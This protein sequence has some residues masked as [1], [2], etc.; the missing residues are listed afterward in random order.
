MTMPFRLASFSLV[1]AAAL[2]AAPANADI[3]LSELVVELQPGKAVREDVEVW[4]NGKERTYVAVEPAEVLNPGTPLE[5]RQQE[6]DPEKRGLL[7]SP[8]RMILEPG[9]RKLLRVATIGAAP[10][11]ERDYRVVVKP[12]VG[13]IEAKQSGLKLLIG[14]EMLVMVRP[15]APVQK[16]SASRA[17]T[18]LTFRN[19]GNVSVEIFDGRQC[20]Q[21][22]KNCAELPGKRLYPGAEWTVKL[23]S[24]SPAEYSV[25]GPDRTDRKTY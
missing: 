8:M 22:R 12:V 19:E 18:G 15:A 21:A 13:Q 20:D 1:F 9:Q 23:P 25:K 17:G 6:A 5:K 7:I 14:Y 24:S 10:S 16:I 11:R 3:V 4:N 2:M